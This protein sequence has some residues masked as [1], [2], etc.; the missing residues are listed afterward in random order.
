MKKLIT[1]KDNICRDIAD[2]LG[3]KSL[4]YVKDLDIKMH[5]REVVSVTVTFYPEKD[6]MATVPAV[7][8]KYNIE[9]VDTD[10][11][12]IYPP[13]SDIDERDL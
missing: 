11:E 7:M 12:K 13:K 3:L 2:A 8:K 9:L 10:K 1:G 6:D 5:L 4:K